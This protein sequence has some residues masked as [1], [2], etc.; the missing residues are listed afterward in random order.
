MAELSIGNMSQNDVSTLS[1]PSSP[2]GMLGMMQDVFA[3]A[4]QLA[5]KRE[6]AALLNKLTMDC[7]K[8][9]GQAA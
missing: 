3:Q 2:D 8:K 9:I 6:I 4:Q 7:I 1:V 5:L